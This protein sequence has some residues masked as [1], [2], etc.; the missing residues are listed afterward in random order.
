MN[1]SY[2]R[3]LVPIVK[4]V[5]MKLQQPR[6]VTTIAKTD[7]H[8]DCRYIPG[9]RQ[10]SRAEKRPTYKPPFPRDKILTYFLD[11]VYH[12]SFLYEERRKIRVRVGYLPQ[13]ALS[14]KD[15]ELSIPPG[16]LSPR[17]PLTSAE[18]LRF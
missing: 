8:R 6:T 18:R 14:N 10:G 9:S 4:D 7:S 1:L 17:R 13:P 15:I 12:T 2:P 11:A 3:D 16:R 5:W